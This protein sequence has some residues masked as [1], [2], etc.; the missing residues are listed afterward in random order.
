MSFNSYTSTKVD[1]LQVGFSARQLIFMIWLTLAVDHHAAW[2]VWGCLGTPS[3]DT[4][5]F[6]LPHC[7]CF[8]PFRPW[9][10]TWPLQP[11][12][13]SAWVRLGQQDT[14]LLQWVRNSA[15]HVPRSVSVHWPPG[16]GA[17]ARI[18]RTN[19]RPEMSIFGKRCHQQFSTNYPPRRVCETGWVL[20]RKDRPRQHF[21]WPV[22]RACPILYE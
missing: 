19:E 6:S 9:M 7:R 20:L 13:G 4:R 11:L 22:W 21:C 10:L 18:L 5:S 17:H 1:G 12:L 3:R 2:A 8:G 15:A 16:Y 14:G